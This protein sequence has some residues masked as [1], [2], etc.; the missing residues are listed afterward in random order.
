MSNLATT[1]V[2]IVFVAS[3]IGVDIWLAVDGVTGN[4]YSERMRAWA[5]V[6]PPLRLIIAMGFGLLCGH[7]F[8]SPVVYAPCQ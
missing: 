1:V 6:W 2:M 7:F 5:K 3:F 4:T 8:W